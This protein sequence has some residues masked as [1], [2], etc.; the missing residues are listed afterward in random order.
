MPTVVDPLTRLAPADDNAG[1]SPPSPRGG[2][3]R[4]FTRTAMT[5]ETTPASTPLSFPR[6]ENV[7]T[8]AKGFAFAA[9]TR[10]YLL[11]RAAWKAS[12]S[13]RH[14]QGGESVRQ[15]KGGEAVN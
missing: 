6:F 5:N 4:E 9:E 11:V 12:P 1:G 15:R 8:S 14:E 2:E 13:T 3:G 10:P 7:E